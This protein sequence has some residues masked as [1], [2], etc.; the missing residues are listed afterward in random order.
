MLTVNTILASVMKTARL[1][2]EILFLLSFGF[3]ELLNRIT[4][5]LCILLLCF[6]QTVLSYRKTNGLLSDGFV[7]VRKVGMV[8]LKKF[9]AVVTAQGKLPLL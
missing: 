3:S 8:W 1:F 7:S 4:T 5:K 6:T 2:P 9:S